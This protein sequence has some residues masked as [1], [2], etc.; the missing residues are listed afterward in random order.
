MIFIRLITSFCSRLNLKQKM[1]LGSSI[2]WILGSLLR[3]RRAEVRRTIRRCLPEKS[4]SEVRAIADG[5]YR[6][7]GRFVVESAGAEKLDRRFIQDNVEIIGLEIIN[8]LLAEGKGII[9][10]SAHI[11]NFDLLAIICCLMGIPLTS[12]SKKLKPKALDDY[13]VA[14]R[15]KHGLKPIPTRHSFRSCISALRRNEVLAFFLDQ[16]MKRDRGIFVDFFGELACTSPGLAQLSAF[17][18]SPVL[19]VFITRT[20]QGGHRVEIFPPLDPLRENTPEACRQ[21]TQRYTSIIEDY[22]RRYPEQWIWLHRRWRTR[23]EAEFVKRDSC[24]PA[25]EKYPG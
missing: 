3:Y 22:I 5:M 6:H 18:G 9:A 23:P 4:E 2:G 14:T 1:A 13:W 16:N 7:L 17:C 19:P 8:K 12:V 15:T 25:Y 20:A 21:A 10:L 24:R 11:G